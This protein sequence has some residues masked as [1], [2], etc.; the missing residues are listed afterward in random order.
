MLR[1]RGFFQR[2]LADIDHPVQFDCHTIIIT[3]FGSI[4]VE[5]GLY[6]Y[7]EN[8]DVMSVEDSEYF[9]R[10]SLRSFEEVLVLIGH[11]VPLFKEAKHT[12]LYR[13]TLFDSTG[14]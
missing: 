13:T 5:R 1:T 9:H 8:K 6:A 10:Q 3:L 14:D 2:Y 11:G 12:H 7:F 4:V